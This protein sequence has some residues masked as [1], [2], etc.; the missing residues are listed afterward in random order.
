MSDYSVDQVNL[1]ERLGYDTFV[2]LSTCFYNK[3]Y[4]DPDDGFRGMFPV[5]K[6]Q[7]IQN[8]YEFFIQ[9]FGG[10]PLYSERKGHPALRARHARFPITRDRATHWLELMREAMVEVG[11]PQDAREQLDEFLTHAAY[12]M[13]NIAE[14]GSRIYG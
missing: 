2:K 10:P 14:D 1:Y 9:R 8:Q 6:Q 3:V 12:F 13:Q 11:I 5:D 7:A 4:S